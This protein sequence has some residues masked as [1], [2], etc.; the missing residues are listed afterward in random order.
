MQA[1]V[2]VDYGYGHMVEAGNGRDDPSESRARLCLGATRGPARDRSRA[3]VDGAK[4]KCVDCRAMR[5]K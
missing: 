3:A 1:G 2:G 4:E 5:P